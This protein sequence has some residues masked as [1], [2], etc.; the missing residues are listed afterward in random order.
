MHINIQASHSAESA[1]VMEAQTE[2]C[3]NAKNSVVELMH[4]GLQE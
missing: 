2:V 3:Q 1:G 4:I